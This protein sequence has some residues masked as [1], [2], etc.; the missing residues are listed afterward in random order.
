MKPS[1]NLWPLG[2][3]LV[4]FF[5]ISGTVGL[6]VMA[7]S[8][9]ADLVTADYYEQEI[10]FQGR[11]DR[12]SRT[13]GLGASVAYEAAG[14]R[15]RICLPNEHAGHELTGRIELYRPSAAG[16]D[17]R[18]SLEPDTHGIQSLD[19]SGLR[20]GLWKVRVSWKVGGEE[21]LMDETVVVSSKVS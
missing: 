17:R 4:F 20:S 3:I 8:Q 9:K 18:L 19:A 11:M 15:I 14:R 7:C 13:R 21:Y 12:L 1:R 2:L 10:K 16:L 6:V 5:F